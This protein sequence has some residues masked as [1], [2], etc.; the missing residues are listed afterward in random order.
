M[1]GPQIE[2]KPIQYAIQYSTVYKADKGQLDSGINHCFHQGP[3]SVVMRPLCQTI[4]AML[5]AGHRGPRGMPALYAGLKGGGGQDRQASHNP[6][7]EDSRQ[8]SIYVRPLGMLDDKKQRNY[9]WSRESSKCA[10]KAHLKVI[11]LC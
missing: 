10:L 4:K 1:V 5:I 7:A 11:L 2:A 8:T 9:I 6:G 3:S